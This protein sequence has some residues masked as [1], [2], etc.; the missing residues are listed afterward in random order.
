MRLDDLERELRAERP[1]IDPEFARKLD[2]WA[3]AGFPRGP[4]DPRGKSAPGPRLPGPFRRAWERLT[5]VPP[6]RIAAPVAAAALLI[7]VVGV[8]I[9]GIELDSDEGDQATLTV[10]QEAPGGDRGDDAVGGAAGGAGERL[11]STA[12]GAA[13]ATAPQ[14]ADE[15]AMPDVVPPAP[16]ESGD[17]VAPNADERLQDSTA[18]LSL[19]ADADE[20]QEVANEVIEVTDRHDGIVMNS[21]V[22]SDQGGARASFDLEIPV[23]NLDAAIEDLSKLGDVIS[24]NEAVEDVTARYVRAQRQRARILDRIQKLRRERL[25]A[26]SR[27]ERLVITSEI[28]SLKAQADALEAQGNQVRREASFATVHVDITSNGPDSDDGW[29]LGDA[30]DDAGDVLRTIAGVALVSLAILVPLGLL[31]AL[32]YLVL[33]RGRRRAR[34]RALGG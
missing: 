34:E 30:V 6:R 8:S 27:Q 33:T 26:D 11:E 14:Q 19:G 32:V 3:E 23:D 16:P 24:R 21:Q 15:T 2:E 22:T 20:V 7:T 29:T 4:L 18:R 9:S 13:P 1:D 28:Q 10:E 17:D 12:E 5:S 31:L 25:E